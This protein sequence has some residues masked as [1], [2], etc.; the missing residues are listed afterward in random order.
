MTTS[1]TTQPA[2]LRPW[3]LWTL[4]FLAFPISGLA[5]T[6]VAGRVDSP[7]AAVLWYWAP[8]RCW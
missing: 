6:A 7:V 8:G 1:S 4:G 5:G 3:L 2:F